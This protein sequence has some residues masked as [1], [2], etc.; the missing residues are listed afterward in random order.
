MSS[1]REKLKII[2]VVGSMNRGG[3]ETWLMHV[4]RHIDRDMFKMDFL[5]H[6]EEKCHYDDEILHLGSKIIPC[7]HPSRP[8]LYAQNFIRII[9]EHGPYDIVH[10]HVHHYSGFVLF[11][12]KMAGV[13][14]RI[15]HSHNDTT[16]LQETAGYMRR[17][18][19][20]LMEYLIK[21]Y[22]TVGL[23]ASRKAAASLYGS[24]WEDDPRWRIL[25]YGIDL[26]L[27]YEDTSKEEV[28][29]EFGINEDAF[30]IGHVGRFHEQKNH[31]FLI[32]IFEEIAQIVPKTIL[33]L[34]G[35][36][37]LRRNIKEKLKDKNLEKQVVFAG[38]RDDVP[39]VM[40]A[41]DIFVMPSLYEGLPVVLLEAQAAGL[42]IIISDVITKEADTIKPLI[43]R[44]SLDQP[45]SYWVKRIME[46]K[47]CYKLQ[48]REHFI[49]MM[50][51]SSFYIENSLNLL[52][53]TYLSDERN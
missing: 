16:L 46:I 38:I 13:Q 9:K 36:G 34:V 50:A 19:L 30:V 31:A 8:W 53:D 7:M 21:R 37:P 29:E 47:N 28:R 35:D 2:H 33:L 25:H 4:L 39:R 42:P 11:L 23:A 1:K 48:S 51:Q 15:A 45:L 41:M 17:S 40:K 5:V 6:T 10:S 44:I 49:N 14:G 18:Y 43:H 52:I 24:Y 20:K 27:F 26:K 3:V 32:D 12:A 22:A